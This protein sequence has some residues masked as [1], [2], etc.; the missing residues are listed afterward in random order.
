MGLSIETTSFSVNFHR[1]LQK[2]CNFDYMLLPQGVYPF[3]FAYYVQCRMSC[4]VVL[5][6][7]KTID[8]IVE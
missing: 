5:C 3:K 2:A 7:K 1:S 8:S 4:N 6:V